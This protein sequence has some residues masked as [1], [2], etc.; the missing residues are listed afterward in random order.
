MAIPQLQDQIAAA[1]AYEDLFVPALFRQWAPLL[2]KA[3]HV[4]PGKRV[5]DVACGTGILVRELAAQVGPAGSVA[6]L[7]L[8]PGMLEVAKRIAPNIESK[9]GTA[10]SLPFSDQSFD[11]VVS[12][13]GLMFFPD[14]T[15]S[16]REMLR[17][18]TP[19]GHL[20]VAVWDS[21]DNIPAIADEVAVLERVAGRAAADAL[22]APFVLGRGSEL[23]R[24][25]RDA[26]VA[27]PRVNTN[28]GTA[29]FP[30]IRTLVEADLR[31]WLPV[32]GVML[33]EETIQRV[34]EEADRALHVYAD[35]NG[36]AVFK[37]SAH[38]LS[39]TRS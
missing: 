39:G 2:A 6:G 15:G 30:S 7:D 9:Q 20:A 35:A 12:Q 25:A 29:R 14:R 22:R 27:E 13:F 19:G 28:P 38:V 26:G 23:E 33:E 24:L 4:G 8:L 32:M 36:R 10:E 17:V 5:L 37:I 31:G 11:V 3:A 1:Q 18:L 16:L 21:L 34:L